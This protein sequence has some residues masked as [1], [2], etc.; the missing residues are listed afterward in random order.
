VLGGF[1]TRGIDPEV[2][3]A[4]ERV[5]RDLESA[6]AAVCP[7]DGEGIDDAPDVWNDLAW[8]EVAA[9]HG[10]LL[11]RRE[12]LSSRTAAL[13]EHGGA[14]PPSRRDAAR[15][16][17][18]QIAGWFRSRLEDVDVLLAP[19]TPYPPPA[20]EAEWVAVGGGRRLDVRLGGASRLCRPV[21]LSGL[22]ALAIPAG[23][24]SGGLPL[25]VQLIG[26]SG[27]DDLLL[28]TAVFLEAR[29]GSER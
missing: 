5:G 4:V 16:R 20:M 9:V 28:S 24:S 12:L 10:H 25:G 21:N 13:L 22:P 1:F 23:R 7:V 17:A 6:G 29:D 18:V 3:K 11:R 8:P 26:R 15:R 2:A 19:S 14:L 27:R